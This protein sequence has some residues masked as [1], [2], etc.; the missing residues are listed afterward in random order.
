MMDQL[1]RAADLLLVPSAQEGFGIPILEA[2]VV[3]LPIFCSDIPPFRETAGEAAH[4]FELGEPPQAVAGR[5]A[6]FLRE[7]PR[8]RLRKR[9]EREFS[10][11]TIFLRQVVPLLQAAAAER[12]RQGGDRRES[13]GALDTGNARRF[14]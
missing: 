7:D 13:V 14:V 1:Y 12:G 6:Q 8:Y 2:G 9:V 4:Y 5:L 10:W 11:E 3:G